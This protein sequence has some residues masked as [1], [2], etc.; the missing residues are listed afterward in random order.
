MIKAFLVG[1]LI[2]LIGQILTWICSQFVPSDLLLAAS[3]LLFGVLS[4]AMIGS[5][6]YAKVMAFGGNG[7]AIPVCGLMF[8][9]ATVRAEAQMKGSSAAKAIW[10]GFIAVMKILG[11]G[12]VLSFILG[13]ALGSIGAPSAEPPGPAMQ[14][15]W[16]VAICGTI[17]AL[18]QL[19]SETKLP[20]PLVAII[21]MVVCGGLLTYTGFMKTLCNLGLG[22]VSVTA[23]GCGNGAYEAGVLLLK[24]VAEP[25][26]VCF[27]LNVVLVMMGAF[28]GVFMLRRN[29]G[30]DLR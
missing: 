28:A 23:L 6:C 19:L 29:Q 16:S 30:G 14:F 17:C 24:G 8:G 1:A 12:F 4:I 10:A 2:G 11:T 27:L 26:I 9:A 20:F 15:V 22:G 5:G 13:L 25:L 18:T 3:I 7:A 21:L